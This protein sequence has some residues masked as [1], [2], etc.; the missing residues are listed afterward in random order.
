QRLMM[1]LLVDA[2]NAYQNGAFSSRSDLQRLHVDAE[3][4]FLDGDRRP[5][6]SI[7]FNM[8]CDALGIDCDDLRRRISDWKH[9]FMMSAGSSL[10]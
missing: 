2:L 10:L 6:N 7:T 8:V 5:G 4:W 9:S 1:A 3:Q